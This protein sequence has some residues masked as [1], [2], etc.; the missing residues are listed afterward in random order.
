MSGDQSHHK[1]FDEGYSK[2]TNLT[3]WC[4][5]DPIT[6]CSDSYNPSTDW[7]L[8]HVDICSEGTFCSLSLGSPFCFWSRISIS[9]IHSLTGW[10]DSHFI[11]FGSPA[12]WCPQRSMWSQTVP[13]TLQHLSNPG[14][15]SWLYSFLIF[16][17]L[18]PNLFMEVILVNEIH[19]LIK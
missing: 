12:D 9:N 18:S 19:N 15:S 6:L 17:C 14:P 4:Q 16:H 8:A 3:P 13:Y 5:M 7:I 10:A 2:D 1:L 11:P